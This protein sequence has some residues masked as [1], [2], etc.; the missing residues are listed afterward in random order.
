MEKMNE[1]QRKRMEES[2]SVFER[3]DPLARVLKGKDSTLMATKD[4]ASM[5]NF[6]KMPSVLNALVECLVEKYIDCLVDEYDPAK[7][8][9]ETLE[10]YNTLANDLLEISQF[11]KLLNNKAQE[12]GKNEDAPTPMLNLVIRTI[13]A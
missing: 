2:S 10:I 6:L 13:G 9:I 12:L 5:I 7:H 4:Y 8:D 3:T 11:L 1:F